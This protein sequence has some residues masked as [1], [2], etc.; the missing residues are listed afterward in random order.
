MI[1][2]KYLI[3]SINEVPR[4]WVF[5]HFCNLTEVLTGQ[6]VNIK[7]MFNLKDK[8]PSMFIYHDGATGIYRFKDFSTGKNGDGVGLVQQLSHTPITRG[9]AAHKIIEIYNQY[10]L[11]NKED[12]S[13]RE[14]KVHSRYKVSSVKERSWTNLDE[15]Y[16][17]QFYIGSKLLEKY[18]IKPIE[19]YNM[20]KDDN[21]K[22]KV[23]TIEGNYIYGYYRK[24]GTLYKIYQPYVKTNK[25]IKIHE[26]IQG[27]DQLTMTKPYLVITSSLKDIMA[28]DKLGFNNVESV[29]PD[30]EN[31]IITD[32]IMTSYKY[33]YKAICTLFDDDTAGI[34][35]M[36]KYNKKYDLPFVHLQGFSKDLSDSIKDHGL[37]KVKLVITELLKEA[38]VPKPIPILVEQSDKAPF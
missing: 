33:K 3:S 15:K 21:G 13:L 14:F 10:R 36:E 23:L 1:S 31:T 22:E 30:S 18:N 17:T 5:E 34:Q 28:F 20:S 8:A 16:W 4:E 29:A 19:T 7:S 11:N 26:Y 38:L 24:D 9:E 25:F 32:V 6:R 37:L 2:T 27:T 35:A 12:I